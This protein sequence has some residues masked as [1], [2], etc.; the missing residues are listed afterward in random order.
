MYEVGNRI[1]QCR[2]RA[3]LSQK[4]FAER[5]GIKPSRAANWEAGTNRPD[6]DMIGNICRVLS[7]SAD[8]L[9]AIPQKQNIKISDREYIGV[10]K[11]RALDSHGK[12]L[13]D[14]V[15]SAEYKRIQKVSLDETEKVIELDRYRLPVSAGTGIFDFGDGE[16]ESIAV[17]ANRYTEMADY[18]VTVR[19]DSMQP[20]YYDGDQL[21]IQCTENL[22]IGEIGVYFVDGKTYVKQAGVGKLIS[23]NP[24]YEPIDLSGAEVFPQGKVIGVLQPEWIVK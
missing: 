21:L 20:R 12:E 7:I 14:L 1:K 10:K 13:V 6:A 18:V 8:E 3:G 9:L 15:L 17:V 4:E 16:K 22:D 19:G 24:E 2:E 5:I 23:L 11:Y